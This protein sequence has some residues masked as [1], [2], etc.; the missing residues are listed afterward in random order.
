M[1]LEDE[2]AALSKY[3]AGKVVRHVR[4]LRKGEVLV[5]FTDGSPLFVDV[6]TDGLE[7]SLSES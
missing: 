1:N 7:C 4:R 2:E 3:L 5:E 6:A